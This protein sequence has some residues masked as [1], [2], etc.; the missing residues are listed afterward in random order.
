[1]NT[2][3]FKNPPAIERVLSV[4]FSELPEFEIVHYGLWYRQIADRFPI[5]TR[6]GRLQ[7]I[8]EPKQW[9][10]STPQFQLGLDI[11]PQ[12]PRVVFA[13]ENVPATRLHQLQPD[14]FAM[15]WRRQQGEDYRRFQQTMHDFEDLFHEF[16]E[17]CAAESLSKP[18]VD[19]CEVIYVNEIPCPSGI[20]ASSFMS[21]VFNGIDLQSP[22]D[23]LN[24][25]I[26]ASV[27]RV[28]NTTDTGR[29][30]VE[31]QLGESKSGEECI[32]MKLTG[33]A[34]VSPDESWL[35]ELTLA[36]DWVVNGFIAITKDSIRYQHW[37]QQ[38]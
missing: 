36:H 2:P 13:S 1:M 12:L 14:R 22:A 16:C 18:V 8:F 28:F 3:V 33:R 26:A 17:F 15:N 25:P 6:Q 21:D 35:S 38:L 7:K 23:W 10:H 30:Y 29:L 24:G 34:K 4:Q 5:H 9:R 31:C 32:T 27:D 11:T 19:L 20:D 37:G